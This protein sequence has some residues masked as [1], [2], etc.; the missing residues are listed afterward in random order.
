MAPSPRRAEISVGLFLLIGLAMAGGLLLRFSQPNRTP[1]GGY[2][3]VV[4][5]KD[6]T[7]IR[8]GV[9]VRLGGVDIGSVSGEP[10]WNDSFTLLSI[11][12]EI[13]PEIR[14]P[15]GSTVKVGSSGLLGDSYVRILPPDQPTGEFIPEGYRIA[16][17][18]SGNLSD[19]A[20]EAGEAFDDLADASVEIRA[21][22]RQVE[23]LA[24]R[25]EQ[26]LLN[27]ENLDHVTHL[28][29]DLRASASNMKTLSS[30][31]LPLLQESRGAIERV[32]AAA[33][34]AQTSFAGID[35][36]V[37]ELSE[38][39][40]TVPPVVKEFDETLDDLRSTLA[41]T[42]SLLDKLENG[43]GLASAMLKDSKLKGDLESFLN[44]L[45][46]QGIL[47]YPRESGSD[48]PVLPGLR[49]QP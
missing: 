31:A 49:R 48:K 2:P 32:G 15:E 9:P 1:H 10:Q 16:A 6:A 8:V 24:A 19:L 14:I 42:L 7:G 28:L 43:D 29:A 36:G 41:A 13:R 11:P 39:L 3:I 17:Q 40:G 20:S 27:D 5:V 25:V 45:N 33:E 12:L 35:Q 37:G 23:R 44:K 22:A 47:F 18:V 38:V 21:A 34:A 26:K 46:R 30:E 4:E